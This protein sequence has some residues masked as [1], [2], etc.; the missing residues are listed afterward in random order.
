MLNKIKG[1]LAGIS[2]ATL[3]FIVLLH[4]YALAEGVADTAIT[5][6]FTTLKDNIIATLGAVVGVAILV[7]AIPLGWRFAKRIFSSV[8][9]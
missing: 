3:A 8:A 6:A 4:S 1:K 5:N 7:Y 2:T 9:R